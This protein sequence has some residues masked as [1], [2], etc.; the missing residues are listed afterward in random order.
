MWDYG[1]SWTSGREPDGILSGP[2]RQLQSDSQGWPVDYV[3][4][5]MRRQVQEVLLSQALG[6]EQT[7]HRKAFGPMYFQAFGARDQDATPSGK[8]Q[9]FSNQFRRMKEDWRPNRDP[10]FW[11][12][13]QAYNN[14]N[15]EEPPFKAARAGKELRALLDFY[16]EPFNLQHNKY[17]LDLIAQKIGP[18]KA[19]WTRSQLAELRFDPEDLMGLN[20]IAASISRMRHSG[21]ELLPLDDPEGLGF[22]V[23][24]RFWHPRGEKPTADFSLKNLRFTQSSEFILNTLLEVRGFATLDTAE[25]VV[26]HLISPSTEKVKVPD[27]VFS[28]T[29]LNCEGIREGSIPESN[30][31]STEAAVSGKRDRALRALALGACAYLASCAPVQCRPNFTVTDGLASAAVLGTSSWLCYDWLLRQRLQKPYLEMRVV[32]ATINNQA[33]VEERVG[34]LTSS[35]DGVEA[36]TEGWHRLYSPS[37]TSV[38]WF[39]QSE[40]LRC[41]KAGILKMVLEKDDQMLDNPY[42]KLSGPRSTRF[43]QAIEHLYVAPRIRRKPGA[44]GSVTGFAWNAPNGSEL[45]IS[46]GQTLVSLSFVSGGVLRLR[47]APSGDISDP[48]HS[49]IVTLPG[50]APGAKFAKTADGFEFASGG[51]KVT[52]SLDPLLLTLHRAEAV[53]WQEL[54][55]MAWNTTSTWQTL[56]NDGE[57]FY[58]CGMQ[59]GYFD[60]TGRFVLIREGGGWDAGGR[61]NPAPFYMSSKSYGVLRNTY[62]PGG[63]NFSQRVM[64]SHDEPGL[65]AF[66]FIGTSMKKVLNLY[67]G[68]AGRPVLPPLWG[69][70]LGDSDCYNNKRHKETS[71]ALAVAKNYSR[72][73]MPRGWM[74]VNDGYGC[75]Y[76]SRNMLQETQEGLES[77]GLRMGLWTSTGLANASWEIGNARSRV[78][79]TDVAWVGSGYRFGLQ[80]VKLAAQL[81]VNA[82]DSRPYT[83]TVCGWAG[84]QKYAVI[85]TGDNSGSWEYIRMQI[86]TMIGSGLSGFAHATGDVDGIF[87]GSAETYVRD[88]QWKTF[89]T[90]AMTMSGWAKYDKQPWVYGEPYTSYNRKW[91]RLKA[92][93]TP[94]LYSL[95]FHAHLTGEPP[96]R[97]MQLE[98]PTEKWS[99]LNQSALQYQF[100]SGPF[101]L[102][103]P[104]F[105]NESKRDDIVL[106]SGEW[107]DYSDGSRFTGPTTLQSYPCPLEELPVFVRAGAIIPMWPQLDYV[108]ETPL[109]VLTLDVYPPTAPGTSSFTLYEDDGV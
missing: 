90:V 16:F 37:L 61:A 22:R 54:E 36:A 60:H 23:R 76:T 39:Y 9:A 55:P 58:G 73:Q 96:V 10:R 20:R 81:M 45:N 85:W 92:R 104:I 50:A 3:D 5:G 95:A 27:K 46:A 109:D 69:L 94:Y 25:H 4:D 82:S 65:D 70:F 41:G 105:R 74:L 59:N 80:A 72:H 64:L 97:A 63:Y 26:A 11:Y 84:T 75:G 47:L 87:G 19:L 77:N 107:I 89:L 18:S 43:P 42:P 49:E 67:T 34:N 79:K 103:A 56:A 102:V 1:G 68:I 99:S 88:L 86:P 38:V 21:A 33:E 17:L 78:I 101:F 2:G 35:I 24:S 71:S 93:L 12:K 91:L 57:S 7:N 44:V 14:Y 66:F 100:M 6:F 106:P 83:W 32:D 62:K 40:H 28:V 15:P 30:V 108:G 53:V 8:P 98:F 51:V 29:S 13:K 52:G 48:M 31:Q